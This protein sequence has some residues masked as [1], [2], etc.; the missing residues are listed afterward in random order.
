MSDAIAQLIGKY[1]DLAPVQK[2]IYDAY[3]KMKESFEV[4][5]KLLVCGNGGSSSDSDHIVG[6]LMK[7][8]LSKR[9]LPANERERFSERF[10]E[11]GADLANL[12]QGS[13]PTIGLSSH[14]ALVSAVANDTDPSMVYAQQVYG[15]G[16]ANDIL[17]GIS[18]SG[19]SQNV[20]RAI[21]V[22]KVKGLATIGLT[23]ATGG[24]MKALCDI[25][26]CVPYVSTPDVQERHLPIYHAL[27]IAIEEALFAS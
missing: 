21:Q 4:G 8:F 26:I 19:N 5:G 23:G 17:F 10:G 3:V 16:K 25:A 1:P 11:E 14:A 22:A 20:I 27:C 7:G 15:Y 24:R 2:D 13:L 9:P 6:E 12:L 18:T